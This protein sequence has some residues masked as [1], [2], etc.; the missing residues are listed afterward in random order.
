VSIVVRAS[1]LVAVQAGTQL[2]DGDLVV[3]LA[4][5]ELSEALNELFRPAIQP[6]REESV[7]WPSSPP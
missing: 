7:R 2:Q 3:I 5:P 6:P 4:D 1:G